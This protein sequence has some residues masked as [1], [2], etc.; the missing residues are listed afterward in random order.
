LV[1]GRKEPVVAP[2]TDKVSLLFRIRVRPVRLGVNYPNM[3]C[4]RNVR[5]SS[6]RKIE[7]SALMGDG[8]ITRGTVDVS[9]RAGPT[10]GAA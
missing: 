8:G 5:S 7:S 1:E 9:K 10:E 2:T 4:S 3:V 6:S